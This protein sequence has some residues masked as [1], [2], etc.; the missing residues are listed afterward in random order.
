MIVAF[1]SETEFPSKTLWKLNRIDSSQ[2]D[3]VL[4]FVLSRV[5]L[6]FCHG[7]AGLFTLGP[8]QTY[9]PFSWQNNK[10]STGSSV[11]PL[12]LSG[13]LCLCFRM[14]IQTIIKVSIQGVYFWSLLAKN[15]WTPNKQPSCFY[16][17]GGHKVLK[18]RKFS[19]S[20]L[21][22][23]IRVRRHS[24]YK[25]VYKTIF[26]VLRGPWLAKRLFLFLLLY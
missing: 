7:N 25:K 15:Y 26:K 2:I 1:C 22:L 8:L 19:S 20:C 14:Y 24:A 10:G 11:P 13:K 6:C 21:F 23:D 3:C 4:S 18:K 9:L 5:C 16:L 17:Q 12:T